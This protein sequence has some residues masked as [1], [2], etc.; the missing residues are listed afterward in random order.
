VRTN[1]KMTISSFNETRKMMNLSE[2]P[3]TEFPPSHFLPFPLVVLTLEASGDFY[4]EI[5]LSD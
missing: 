3:N 5:S 1:A 2:N 4:A